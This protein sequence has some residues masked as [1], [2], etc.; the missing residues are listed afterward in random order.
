MARALPRPQTRGEELANSI[1]HGA[2]CL[3]GI[4]GLVRVVFDDRHAGTTADLVG[5]VIYAITMSA[6]YMTSA[7]YHGLAD[8]RAKQIFMKLDY[9]AIYL[10]IAGTYT[11]FTLGVLHGDWGW[12]LLVAVWALALI[13]VV[14]RGF[15]VLSHPYITTALY[16][17]MGWL[18][19]F[20]IRPLLAHVPAAGIAWL[21]AGGVAYTV[22]V[23][24]Y[25]LDSR[26]KF[27]HLVWHLFVIAGSVCHFAAVAG[28]ASI[29]PLA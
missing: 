14:M 6:L 23:V 19:L 20:A 16:L 2:G 9:C 25:L 21:V 27:A 11:P 28:Y 5:L 1:S 24:F 10:F 8:G 4:I 17:L 3:I 12:A 26:F 22:G 15:D 13:G 29:T 18:V 7:I